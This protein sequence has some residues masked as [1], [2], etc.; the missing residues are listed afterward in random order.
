M[1]QCNISKQGQCGIFCFKY[2]LSGGCDDCE[3]DYIK[4]IKIKHNKDERRN[5]QK[6][7]D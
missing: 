5:I 6:G 7:V 1:D 3:Q 2:W 4:R